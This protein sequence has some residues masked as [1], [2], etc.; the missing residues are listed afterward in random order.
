MLTIPYPPEKNTPPSFSPENNNPLQ[1]KTLTNRWGTQD[2][3]KTTIHFSTGERHPIPRKRS[4]DRWGWASF[5]PLLNM[6]LE[7]RSCST[8]PFSSWKNCC[9]TKRVFWGEKHTRPRRLGFS[10][11]QGCSCFSYMFFVVFFVVLFFSESEWNPRWVLV[12]NCYL[13]NPLDGGNF[14]EWISLMGW[15]KLIHHRIRDTFWRPMILSKFWKP[16][17]CCFKVVGF[18][19]FFQGGLTP[20]HC[21]L[22]LIYRIALVGIEVVTWLISFNP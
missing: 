8:W 6:T 22:L 21:E 2:L 17:I 12:R 15:D 19:S 18:F 4:T 1:K 5:S 13:P 14:Q 3:L 20:K 7:W 9:S 16:A 10:M 11:G